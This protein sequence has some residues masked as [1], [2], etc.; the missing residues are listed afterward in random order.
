MSQS[1]RPLPVT[2]EQLM[3]TVS[4]SSSWTAWT[5]DLPRSLWALE[6]SRPRPGL[7]VIPRDAKQRH[8]N[9]HWWK[10]RSEKKA[11]HREGQGPLGKPSWTV[12]EGWDFVFSRNKLQLLKKECPLTAS[13]VS[14][15]FLTTSQTWPV[16]IILGC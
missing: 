15:R 4:N 8:H 3:K 14:L 9:G 5:A 6:C 12:E 11:D 10:L 16:Q 2:S 7:G 13:S 1:P